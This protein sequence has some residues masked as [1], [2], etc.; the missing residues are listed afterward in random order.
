MSN[1]NR[2]SMTGLADGEIVLI[3]TTPAGSG[4]RFVVDDFP[5]ASPLE[6]FVRLTPEG[7]A[8]PV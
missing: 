6:L 3:E 5:G 4:E 2:L 8:V 7:T 1:N